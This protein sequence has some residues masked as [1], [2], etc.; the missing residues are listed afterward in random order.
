MFRN[1]KSFNFLFYE[2]A[3]KNKPLFFLVFQSNRPGPQSKVLGGFAVTRQVGDF[4]VSPRVVLHGHVGRVGGGG[5]VRQVCV[6]RSELRLR[7][8][9]SVVGRRS[10]R[11]MVGQE[12]LGVVQRRIGHK[13]GDHGAV[14]V[15]CVRREA[16]VTG[17]LE[18]VAELRRRN[19][20]PQSDRPGGPRQVTGR[21]R[22][23]LRRLDERSRHGAREADRQA[24]HVRVLLDVDVG[25]SDGVARVVGHHVERVVVAKVQARTADA[26]VDA[27]QVVL[28]LATSFVG[29]KR[30]GPHGMGVAVASLG[31]VAVVP[32]ERWVHVVFFR[33]EA[34]VAHVV[35]GV[36]VVGV[37]V[38]VVLKVGC[39]RVARRLVE[40]PV[41]GV[42]VRVKRLVSL[43]LRHG[44]FPEVK[45]LLGVWVHVDAGVDAV[46]VASLR[47]C[48]VDKVGRTS[49]HVGHRRRVRLTEPN[50]WCLVC[51]K[52]VGCFVTTRLGP[53]LPK[54]RRHVG[55]NS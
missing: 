4:A 1:T 26:L 29:S 28:H 13:G 52:A 47:V 40:H 24:A 17:R 44:L 42:G 2:N 35:Q 11:S 49:V 21:F 39:K 15:R 45:H 43:P 34:A 55:R 8:H 9:G 22:H 37:G 5:P 16:F 18:L 23:A 48:L 41:H 7:D 10:E 12:R 36:W 46:V 14:Q 32:R 20:G 50:S 3:T 54:R 19:A 6:L 27:R 31:L 30:V 33:L 38:Q 25:C 53:K 51:C